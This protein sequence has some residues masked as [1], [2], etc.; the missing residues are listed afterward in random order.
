MVLEMHFTFTAQLQERERQ[1]EMDG[2][3]MWI[4][5]RRENP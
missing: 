4:S 1:R 2:G 5:M 3:Q